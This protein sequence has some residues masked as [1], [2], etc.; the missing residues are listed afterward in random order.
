MPVCR[1][2]HRYFADTCE[3]NFLPAPCAW[4]TRIVMEGSQPPARSVFGVDPLDEFTVFVS[5]W[6]WE[7]TRGL[8]N[9]EVCATAPTDSV[10]LKPRSAH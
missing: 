5:D 7:R 1:L 6:I 8:S 10:R 3:A 2:S 9:V 4:L